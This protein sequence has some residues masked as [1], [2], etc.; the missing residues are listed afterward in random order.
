MGDPGLATRIQEDIKDKRQEALDE[1]AAALAME[2]W[3]VA[4][5]VR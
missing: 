2:W 5:D 1:A 3:E 4:S